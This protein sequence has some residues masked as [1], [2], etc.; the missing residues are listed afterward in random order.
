MAKAIYDFDGDVDHGELT[1]YEN[2]I[3]T[4]TSQDVGEGWWE[5]TNSR[6]QT[7]L[8][9]EAYVE[10]INEAGPPAFA[11]PMPTFAPPAPQTYQSSAPAAYNPAPPSTDF[12]GGT[13]DDDWDDW[14]DDSSSYSDS[15]QQSTVGSP[16]EH[17]TNH[18]ASR[19]GT[20]TIKTKGFNRFST[21]VKLG[22]EAYILGNAKAEVPHGEEIRIVDKGEGPRWEDNPNT[23]TCSIANPKKESKFK[24]VKSYI[25]YQVTPSHTHIQVSRR[26]KHFD[27]LYSRLVDKYTI[28]A[29]PPLPDKQI[30]GRYEDDFIQGRMSQ[31]QAWMDRMS[32]HPVISKS[33]VLNH[34]LTCTDEKMWKQG[35]RKAEKDDL[36]GASFFLMLQTPQQPLD[37]NMVEFQHESLSKFSKTMD[38]SVTKLMQ[39]LHDRE[40]KHQGPFRKEFNKLGGALNGLAA[41]FELDT[42]TDSHP[43]TRAVHHTGTTYE[44]IGT[45]YAEQPRHD[46]VPMMFKLHEYEGLLSTFPDTLTVH[47]GALSKVKECQKQVDEGKMD[48]SDAASVS[49]RADTISYAL[50]AESNHFQQERVKDFKSMMQNFVREQITFYKNI[51]EKLE[52]TL[53]M[54]DEF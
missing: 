14:D 46:L 11:P 27:W 24:G 23:F 8:F 54:Y 21:F 45:M 2:D 3:L 42:N 15:R 1:I 37:S 50:L 26:Y 48:G 40:K 39:V 19:K 32:Q 20:S 16:T 22:G 44:E 35:K 49:Q 17:D 4:V 52:H 47:K 31:L 33:Q 38:D 6:G 5:G 12:D 30:T 53:A 10:L 36:V 28:I 7:G 51:T 18:F 34:F 41:S 9:P 43:L 13:A 29:V 25:A